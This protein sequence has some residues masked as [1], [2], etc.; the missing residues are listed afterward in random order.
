M[1]FTS[2]L[3]SS[4]IIA[5]AFS[6]IDNAVYA[7]DVGEPSEEHVEALFPD[8]PAYSPWAGR[9]FP[10]RPFFGDTHLH[11]ALSLD[12]GFVGA[13]LRPADAYRFSKGEMLTSNTGLPVKLSRPLD[14]VV[15]ADHSDNLGFA[16]DFL[17]GA[18]NILAVPE[19]KRWYEMVQ[20]GNVMEAFGEFLAAF[21]SK[22]LP[23]E[24]NYAPGN[25]G[26]TNAWNEI[27]DAAEEANDPGKFTAFIG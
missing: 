26:Y 14:F 21:S 12:A 20:E 24:L 17:A 3:R 22:S 15:V 19:G 16:T 9:D 27:I 13:T 7:S 5:L 6:L 1:A 10:S 23:P 8:K 18:P 4:V 25:P 2:C 11:T